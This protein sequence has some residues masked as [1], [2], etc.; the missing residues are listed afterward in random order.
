MTQ[1]IKYDIQRLQNYCNEH[2]LTLIDDYKDVFLTKNTPIKGKCNNDDCNNNFE[3][4]FINLINS[5]GYCKLCIQTI[6]K[7]RSKAT[8]FEKYGGENNPNKL[9]LEKTRKDK[10]HKVNLDKI[11][12]FCK[13]N[14]IEIVNDYTN[15]YLT[16]HSYIKIKCVYENC[17][18]IFEKRFREI[19][20]TGAYCQVCINKVKQEK[21]KNTCLEKYGV[22]SSI[23]SEIVKEKIKATNLQKYGVEWS[24]QSEII[25]GKIKDTLLEKYGVENAMQSKEIQ[26]KSKQTCLDK[27]GVEHIYKSDVFKDKYNATIL[28]KY[29]VKSI[30]QSQEIKNK[31]IE[32]SLKNYGVEYPSQNQEIK[33]KVKETNLKNYG[34]EYPTQNK[35]VRNKA[36]ENNLK[37]YGVEHTFQNENIKNKIKETNI[38]NLGVEYPTQNKEVRNKVKETNIKNLGVEYPIQND[39]VKNKTKQTCL[40]KYGCECPLQNEEVKNKSKQTCLA[41]YGCEYAIQNNEIMEQIINSSFTK[42][43]YVYPSGRIDKIQGYEHFALDELIINEKIDESDIITG[44]K[45]VP[46][47]LYN[48]KFGK[49]HRHYVDI[50]I[51]SQNKCIEVKSS[52]TYNLQID[53]VLLKQNA[54]K[55]LGYNYEIWIYDNKGNKKL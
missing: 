12:L 32:T 15:S 8:L 6:A 9:E 52:W 51:P 5:G 36:I 40:A 39:E 11:I 21:R 31:K 54:A 22:E 30:S 28:E 2:N 18:T 46:K 14:N 24:F 43:E 45:N 48:D 37:K 41:K 10:I 3:K 23:N 47:I 1:R 20:H 17:S 13:N 33:D 19:E 7:E 34:V 44:C 27:Y 55:E 50:F 35:E 4:V 29:G 16:T 38:K 49:T 42:K 25:K 26:E 53:C